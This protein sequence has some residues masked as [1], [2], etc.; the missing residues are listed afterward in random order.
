MNKGLQMTAKSAGIGLAV[1]TAA[2][3]AGSLVM[4][5]KKHSIKRKAKHAA[6]VLGDMLDSVS[7][8]FH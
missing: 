8:I 1:G 7:M 3:L 6:G 5:S 2:G 4:K